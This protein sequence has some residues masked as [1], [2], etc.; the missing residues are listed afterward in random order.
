MK[1]L[2]LC[3]DTAR[4]GLDKLEAVS[5]THLVPPLFLK[6][7][8]NVWRENHDFFRSAYPGGSADFYHR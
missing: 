8:R 4:D 2:E 5:Y 3:I 6:R 7:S 1:W